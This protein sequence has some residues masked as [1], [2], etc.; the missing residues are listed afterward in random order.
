MRKET[1]SRRGAEAQGSG[2]F[3]AV[4]TFVLPSPRQL[5]SRP[6]GFARNAFNALKTSREAARVRRGQPG[7]L[8]P[9]C[10]ASQPLR[11][12]LGGGA[13]V[14]RTDLTPLPSQTDRSDPIAFFLGGVLGS[15]TLLIGPDGCR[16]SPM[17]GDN[18]FR[19]VHL[20]DQLR[21]RERCGSTGLEV[22]FDSRGAGL[23]GC[24]FACIV[25][26]RRNGA[27]GDSPGWSEAE[28][29]DPRRIRRP[30]GVDGSIAP[31]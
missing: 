13:N 9:R 28:P 26:Q 5:A 8:R 22:A 1:V 16:S 7:W 10:P 21:S 14:K 25:L 27:P 31:G 2:M 15:R 29:W 18:E 3:R 4:A 11:A 23:A 19:S 30:D 20:A 24:W 17:W 6:R 12:P